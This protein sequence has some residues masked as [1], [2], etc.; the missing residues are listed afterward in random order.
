M[1]NLN[2][3]LGG[4]GAV[5]KFENH[6]ITQTS[7]S[8]TLSATENKT[9]FVILTSGGGGGGGGSDI[10]ANDGAGGGGGGGH[11]A[12]AFI[13]VP[14]GETLYYVIGAGGGRG[15]FKGRGV[16]GGN[17]YIS[18]RSD[19]S[20]PLIYVYGGNYGQG[21]G[22]G[23]P[24][25]AG[26]SHDIVG[27]NILG[28]IFGGKGGTGTTSTASNLRPQG[29]QSQLHYHAVGARLL[30]S[31]VSSNGSPSSGYAAGGGGGSSWY[32][33]GA[34]GGNGNSSG[35]GGSAPPAP[36]NNWGAGG[37]GGGAGTQNGNVFGS[38]GIKG[39]IEIFY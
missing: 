26:T 24:G 27:M 21:G 14:A 34:N 4:G 33:I 19:H 5:N 23:T 38:A 36:A 25:G 37:G 31:P 1:A 9:C 29:V 3:F 17:S 28:S 35:L 30:Q 20:Q 15:G 39:N 11:T 32:G 6:V 7:G 22:N 16:D 18:L 10:G 2:K 13:T 8:L 12:S